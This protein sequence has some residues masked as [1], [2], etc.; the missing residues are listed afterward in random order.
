M[1]LSWRF[2]DIA[3]K[4][5]CP[6]TRSPQENTLKCKHLFISH[7]RMEIILLYGELSLTRDVVGQMQYLINSNCAVVSQSALQHPVLIMIIHL[8]VRSFLV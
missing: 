5:L 2:C 8:K 7:V 3:H 6:P 1:C 4:D